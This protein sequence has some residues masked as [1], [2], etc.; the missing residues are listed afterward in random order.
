MTPPEGGREVDALYDTSLEVTRWLQANYPQLRGFMVFISELGRF[1]FYLIIIPLLYWC[2]HK[3]LGKHAA[4]LLAIAYIANAMLKD[5][6]REPRPYWLDEDVGWSSEPTYGIPSGHAQI[7][8]PVYLLVAYRVRR[9]WVWLVAFILIFLIG[10]SRIYLGVHFFHDVAAGLLV[11]VLILAGYFT[12]LRYFH[13]QFRNHILGQR[14]LVVVL[15]PAVLALIYV[16]VLALLGEPDTE[17]VWAAFSD[18]AAM[19]GIEE[20]TAAVGILLGLGVGF[21]VEA[22][23]VHFV[24]A[25]SLPKRLLRYLLGMMVTITIWRGLAL[26]FPDDPLWLALPLRFIRYWLAGLW[27]AY[28]A[29]LVFVRLGLADASPEPEV[30]LTVSEGSIMRS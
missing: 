10:L 24:V 14:L 16:A 28:Y 23:R 22:T 12:W 25:G 13:E 29:P 30:R 7:V 6:L 20:M 2:I 1:Q 8:L 19:V 4:Y 17:V 18:E 3:Q 5:F 26:L 27:V 11:G 21:V 15:L 9:R